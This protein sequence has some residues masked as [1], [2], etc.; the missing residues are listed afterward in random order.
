MIPYKW[1]RVH[2][3][4]DNIVT[5]KD[6]AERA[7]VS[8]TVVS[9]VTN[10]NG[11]VAADKRKRVEKVI[12]E[13][14][15]SPNLIA[16]GLK[17]NETKQ[18]LFYA[19]ELSNPFYVEVYQGMEDYAEKHGYTIVVSRHYDDDIIYQRKID[20]MILSAISKKRQAEF[21]KLR[22]PVVVTNYSG[23]TLEI[24]SVGIDMMEGARKAVGYLCEC[25]HKRIGFIT[26]ISIHQEQRYLGYLQGLKEKNIEPNP[27]W[28][29][30]ENSR[31][32][33][34]DQ[35]YRAAYRLLDQKPYI[36]AIFV[37]ND[38]M[39]IGVIAALS[40]RGIRIPADLSIIGFDDILQAK[41]TCPPL[42]TIHI[43]KYEQGEE[44][45]RMLI[46]KIKGKDVRNT[47]LRTDLIIRG[48]VKGLSKEV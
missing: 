3:G 46:R 19:P 45:A 17:T 30:L 2:K 28:V 35:G 27:N 40:E 11:Y 13:L 24:P 41:Y 9:R 20:G 7:N 26:N 39:A 4:G 31:G 23:E 15:Y 16:R 47:T 44:S 36:T 22:V 29:L 5:R 6:V 21:L 32:T 48:S 34:Y 37:F 38:A 42:T 12:E 18:I 1:T 33:A 43:P 8:V 10:N 14:G 25:N